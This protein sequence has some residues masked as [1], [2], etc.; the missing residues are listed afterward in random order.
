MGPA[1]RRLYPQDRRDAGPGTTVT[2]DA[3]KDTLKG[4]DGL[5]WFFANRDAGLKDVLA[6]RLDTE[7]LDELS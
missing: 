6:D 2:D 1:S 3:A 7:R 4:G 5:D